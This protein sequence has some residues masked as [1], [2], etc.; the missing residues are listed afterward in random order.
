MFLEK[1]QD[2]LLCELKLYWWIYELHFYWAPWMFVSFLLL[3]HYK[4]ID[5]R[6]AR[7]SPV[8]LMFSGAK[9]IMSLA[10]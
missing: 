7:V 9:I 8:V 1:K 10:S 5:Y 4:G 2:C 3:V 6:P